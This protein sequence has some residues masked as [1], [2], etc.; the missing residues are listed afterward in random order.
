MHVIICPKAVKN[1]RSETSSYQGTSTIIPIM[2]PVAL[3]DLHSQASHLEHPPP[4]L[5]FRQLYPSFKGQNKSY[6][7]QGASLT[8]HP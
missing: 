4:S 6:L 8:S 7:L 2:T 5:C 1:T 3:A